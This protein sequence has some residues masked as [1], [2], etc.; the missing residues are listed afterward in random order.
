ML[1]KTFDFSLL[2]G[3]YTS[4]IADVK[5]GAHCSVFNLSLTEKVITSLNATGRVLYITGD[6]LSAKKVYELFNQ[7]VKGKAFL[8]PPAGDNL[9]YSVASY[10][11]NNKERIKTIYNLVKGTAKVVV[12]DAQ[13]IMQF[14]PQKEIFASSII[15]IDKT[16]NL[17]L[18]DFISKM[19]ECG[20]TREP[21]IGAAGQFSVRG[22]IVD[23]FPVN[24]AFP[25]RVELFDDEIESIKTFDVA[26]QKSISEV[27]G[28][29]I[30]P[31]TDFLVSGEDITKLTKK[32]DAL[33]NA[34]STLGAD[35][36]ARFNQIVSE[37]KFKLENNERTFKSY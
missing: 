25:F 27:T 21:L 18:T 32:L 9:V 29:D 11:E 24:S 28:I 36:R 31:N 5:N 8:L 26:T 30:C 19:V 22:D 16:K 1:E 2:G 33:V 35:E 6:F 3:D 14:L 12:A 4:F 20:Y 7:L 17:N 13:S 34:A 15:K 37:I 23:V 10:N